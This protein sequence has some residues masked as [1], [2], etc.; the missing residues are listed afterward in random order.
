MYS[1]LVLL[2]MSTSAEL[3]AIRAGMFF[4]KSM[5]FR[6]IK[7]F[8]DSCE[9]IQLL[10]TGVAEGHPLRDVIQETR[11]LIAQDWD[12]EIIQSFR[13]ALYMLCG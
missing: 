6:K 8:S 4:C 13:E 7:L 12:L 9:A 2:C 5:G 3:L 1:T 11:E 10:L